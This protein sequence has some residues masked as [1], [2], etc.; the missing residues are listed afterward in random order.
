MRAWS[1]SSSDS[2]EMPTVSVV[3]P[4]RDRRPALERTLAALRREYEL[5]EVIVV[6]D[7]SLDDTASWLAAE[8]ARWPALKLVATAG[9]GSNHA[10]AEGVAHATGEVVLLID[11]DVLPAPG[12]V[13]G[14]ARHH[15]DSTGIVVSGYYPV[16]L[17]TRPPATTRLA[18]RWYEDELNAVDTDPT[19]GF[20]QLW[21]GQFS[22]RRSDLA[23]TL[24]SVPEFEGPWR[25]ADRDFGLRCQEAGLRHVFDRELRSEHCFARTLS[26]FRTDAHRSGYG[27]VLVNRLHADLL[28]PVPQAL[29]QSR[30]RVLAPFLRMTDLRAVHWTT[31]AALTVLVRF[32]DATRIQPLADVAVRLLVLIERR[33]GARTCLA[34][35]ESATRH[36]KFG[37]SLNHASAASPAPS[38][39]PS[40]VAAHEPHRSAIHD[41]RASG[42]QRIFEHGEPR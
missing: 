20:N 16:A 13:S 19:L 36:P 17:G 3:I 35:I 5:T 40:S 25:H 31:A 41:G 23:R 26:Q 1:S 34:E 12:L 2:R 9:V 33:R 18:A 37:R 7:A 8:A 32:G 38:A 30:R 21:G 10:R 39:S 15:R 14:H 42:S 28:G 29:L 4:T 6:N 27:A 22:I 24:L 11:D